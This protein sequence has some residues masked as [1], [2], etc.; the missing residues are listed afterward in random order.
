[1]ISVS[2]TGTHSVVLQ[3]TASATAGVNYNVYRGLSLDN[4]SLIT[5]S[6]ISGTTYTDTDPTLQSGS[7]YY[8]VVTAVNSSGVE[9]TDS[10]AVSA[11]IP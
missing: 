9:S 11:Q 3:W 8:Y 5:T 6:P 4:Y 7:T 1:M 10:N 2:G